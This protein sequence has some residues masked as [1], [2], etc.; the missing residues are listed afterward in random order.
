[1]WGLFDVLSDGVLF[2]CVPW[3]STTGTT[4]YTE[5][6]ELNPNMTLASH[7][8]EAVS[9][10]HAEPGDSTGR[11]TARAFR[12]FRQSMIATTRRA[13]AGIKPTTNPFTKIK[14]PCPV[15]MSCR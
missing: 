6:T 3:S 14:F 5:Y 8:D 7:G 15:S 1:M 2:S 10:G 13:I 9:T 4:E 11:D 12:C